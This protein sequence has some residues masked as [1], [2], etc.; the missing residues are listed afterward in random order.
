[1]RAQALASVATLIGGGATLQQ[2]IDARDVVAAILAS[3]AKPELA[4]TVLDLGGPECLS[5]R[6][7]VMRAAAL[8]GVQPRVVPIPLALVRA[9]AALVTRLRPDPP[10]TPAMLGVLQHD[11]RVDT[12]EACKL[13]GIELTS[14][15]AT[16]RACVGPEPPSQ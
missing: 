3:L 10:I 7:L 9:F 6:Q 1:L 2:P 15:D 8:H 11:D 12:A 13:L 14:L 16:L 4:D 5:H